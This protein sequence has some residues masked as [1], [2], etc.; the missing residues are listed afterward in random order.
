M[1]LDA[2]G[3]IYTWICVTFFLTLC[4]NMNAAGI[5]KG[6]VSSGLLFFYFFY[7][8]SANFFLYS[9]APFIILKYEQDIAR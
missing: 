4:L 2:Y 5:R 1:I 8:S 7:I 9:D 3:I 6:S